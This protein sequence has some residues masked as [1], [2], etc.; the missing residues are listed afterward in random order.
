MT[1]LKN[2]FYLADMDND[3]S[4]KAGELASLLVMDGDHTKYSRKEL[5]EI[6]A[7]VDYN[8]S[9][10][11]EESELLI[12][13]AYTKPS[14]GPVV[15]EDTAF[16]NSFD[17]DGDGFVNLDEL[18]QKMAGFDDTLTDGDIS[19]AFRKNDFDRNEKLN[20][21]EFKILMEFDE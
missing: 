5:K 4:L 13:M 20:Q 14:P 21:R 18:R 10:T 16:F 1:E 2:H 7:S 6:I 17:A 12:Y 15:D 19:A 3:K 8:Y 9:E 11:M